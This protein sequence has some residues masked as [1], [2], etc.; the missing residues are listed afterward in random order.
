MST[1]TTVP[2][3]K[4]VKR[5]TR[6]LLKLE[7]GKAI[8]VEF[9]EPMFEAEAIGAVR[10]RSTKKP[11]DGAAA[12]PARKMAPP[13]LANVKDLVHGGRES[14]IICN[15]VLESELDKKYP[16]DTY[17]G[18]QFEIVKNQLQGKSYATFEIAEVQM[19]EPDKKK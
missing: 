19:Q 4:V 17:V 13:V 7:L 6:P 9:Q 15:A 10:T 8:Y 11:V 16:K 14:Q 2:S 3:F 5:V 1:A 12:E 18:K